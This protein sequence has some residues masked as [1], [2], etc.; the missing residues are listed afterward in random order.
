LE[1][2]GI[3]EPYFALAPGATY[4]TKRWPADY[5]KEL[6]QIILKKHKEPIVLLG[7]EGERESFAKLMVSE[8][9]INLAGELNLQQAAAVLSHA[10]ALV[11]NDSGLMHMA[12]AVKTPVLAIFGSTV[13]EL[14]FF[15]YRSK[16]FVMENKTVTCRPCSHV[17]RHSCPK[18]HFKCMKELK[19]QAAYR[20]FKRLVS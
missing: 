17:G 1:D 8:R 4:Y 13:K 9:V 5:F 18:G 10:T 19:P 3:A 6:I 12:T 16:Y 14:G 11:S 15:P 2:K 20:L 7:S